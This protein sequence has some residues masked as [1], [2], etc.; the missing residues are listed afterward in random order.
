MAEPR[1]RSPGP[2][3]KPQTDPVELDLFTVLTALGSGLHADLTPISVEGQYALANALVLA[4]GEENWGFETL[5][6]AEVLSAVQTARRAFPSP[7]ALVP[8]GVAEPEVLLELGIDPDGP[9]NLDGLMA[10]GMA[11]EV[12]PGLVLLATP[13]GSHRRRDGT[14]SVQVKLPGQS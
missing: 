4:S 10:E 6:V 5:P 7:M 14:R 12:V 9:D 2:A 11:R 1:H 13:G 8:T 3:D